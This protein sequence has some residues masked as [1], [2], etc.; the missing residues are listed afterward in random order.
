MAWL[1]IGS[2]PPA[3]AAWLRSQGARV[4]EGCWICTDEFVNEPY[5]LQLGDRVGVG[6]GTSF[7]THEG[8][9]DP[10][11][12]AGVYGPITV[13][14]NTSI[15]CHCVLL[16]GTSIG[17]NCVVASGSVVQGTFPDGSVVAGNPA[18]VVGTTAAALER[19]P[20]NT[21]R[22]KIHDLPAPERERVLRERFGLP[23]KR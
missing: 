4:G 19:P 14:D 3:R 21:Q 9:P 8:S 10:D 1:G 18:R 11:D 5:L 16:P 2:L 20:E 17:R 23:P 7:V 22:L 6:F 12:L 13:G 15:G